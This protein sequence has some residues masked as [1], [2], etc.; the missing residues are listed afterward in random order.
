MEKAKKDVVIATLN[1]KIYFGLVERLKKR[2]IGFMIKKPWETIPLG[3]RVVFT[4]RDE[5][6]Y[7]KHHTILFCEEENLDKVVE[8][9]SAIIQG[10]D[11]KSFDELIVGIDPGK[12]IGLAVVGRGIILKSSI[13]QNL[14]E[15]FQTLDKTV[16]SLKPKK[17]LVKV[18]MGGC[19]NLDFKREIDKFTKLMWNK[20]NTPFEVLFVDEKNTTTIIK[21][22]K[23]KKREK[24]IASA[25]EIALRG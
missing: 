8:E 7:V 16:Q 22:R 25:V 9:A 18:G 14:K 13:H 21:R 24:D 5:A 3:V 20:L 11:E 12:T 23:I 2:N 4:T 17:V 6:V 1:G 15:V 19:L 10:L